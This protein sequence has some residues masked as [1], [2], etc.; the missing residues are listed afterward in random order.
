MPSKNNPG[1]VP[2]ARAIASNPAL[3]RN[4][5]PMTFELGGKSPVVVSR[6]AL[7][8]TAT[9][10]SSSSPNKGFFKALMKRLLRGKYTNN[11]QVCVC[12]DYALVHED[13]YDAFVEECKPI[14]KEFFGD[15][16]ETSESYGRLINDRNFERVL[17]LRDSSP[18]GKVVQLTEGL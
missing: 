16:A 8:G 13:V 9:S 15:S 10:S 6:S 4:L 5:T 12:P 2:I 17:A 7:F 14:T 3:G 1:S 18:G 11:G